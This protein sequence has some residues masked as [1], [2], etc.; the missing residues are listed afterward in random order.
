MLGR[1]KLITEPWDIGPGGYQLG[2]FPGLCRMERQI[3]RH[4]PQ[5]L[6]RRSRAAGGSGGA[7]DRI[8]GSV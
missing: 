1:L 5:V 6:A 3:P 2:N 8:G 7:A 4:R